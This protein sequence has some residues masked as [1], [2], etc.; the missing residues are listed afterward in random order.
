MNSN[1]TAIILAGGRS[2]RMGFDKQ[3]LR[4]NDEY[5][6]EK[7]LLILL[8]LFEEVIVVSN[9]PKELWSIQNIQRAK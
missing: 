2:L 3:L 5:L 7:N 1:S 9:D 8:E 4:L 6:L